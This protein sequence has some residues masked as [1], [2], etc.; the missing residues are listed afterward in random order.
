M[1]SIN[2]KIV[3]APQRSVVSYYKQLE[4]L[5]R[6]CQETTCVMRKIVL[7][8]REKSTKD[9]QHEVAECL[10][11]KEH[12][13]IMKLRDRLEQKIAKLKRFDRRFNHRVHMP[14]P[15]TQNP[16]TQPVIDTGTIGVNNQKP[17]TDFN[18]CRRLSKPK[19]DH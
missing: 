5:Y 16:K 8:R 10:F 6:A 14:K 19:S 2:G 12:A 7:A 17:L 11:L 1:M 4:K 13:P 15:T 3:T 9:Y 18:I